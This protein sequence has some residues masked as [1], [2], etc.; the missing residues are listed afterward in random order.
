MDDASYLDMTFK[1]VE[2]GGKER[3]KTFC[4]K[5]VAHSGHRVRRELGRRSDLES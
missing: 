4:R 1:L 3:L 2:H 5:D